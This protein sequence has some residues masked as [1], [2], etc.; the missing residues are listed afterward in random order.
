MSLALPGMAHSLL[1]EFRLM[2]IQWGVLRRLFHRDDH[3]TWVQTRSSLLWTFPDMRKAWSQ[4]LTSLFHSRPLSPDVFTFNLRMMLHLRLPILYV[5]VFTSLALIAVF[6]LS[7]YSCSMM[8]CSGHVPKTIH[9]YLWSTK[10]FLE[11]FVTHLWND[12]STQTTWKPR[13]GCS[14][15]AVLT[16]CI[17]P[18]VIDSHLTFRWLPEVSFQQ[19]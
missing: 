14:Q 1:V 9:M 17:C 19:E 6:N 16:V 4:V 15:C 13:A 5:L 18:V 12:T 7:F 3:S 2:L 8:H 11:R 10:G